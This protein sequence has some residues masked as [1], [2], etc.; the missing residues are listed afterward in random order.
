MD[1]RTTPLLNFRVD[2]AAT[3]TI[4]A[5][6]PAIKHPRAPEHNLPGIPATAERECTLEACLRWIADGLPQLDLRREMADT[7]YSARILGDDGGPTES[8]AIAARQLVGA[9]L[10]GHRS[11][12]AYGQLCERRGDRIFSIGWEAIPPDAWWWNNIDWRLSALR[13]N[14]DEWRSIRITFPDMERAFPAKE[15]AGTTANTRT[16][17]PN[18]PPTTILELGVEPVKKEE[19]PEEFFNRRCKE[20]RLAV[21]GPITDGIRKIVVELDEKFSGPDRI[22]DAELADLFSSK[23]GTHIARASKVSRG[24]RM[25]SLKT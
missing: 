16:S 8:Y 4:S 24:R 3:E 18:D 7:R 6:P 2:P 5:A 13:R 20:E 12:T 11:L 10:D 22:S 14:A 9:L 1:R 17:R 23:P 21:H 19:R 15:I 25:R